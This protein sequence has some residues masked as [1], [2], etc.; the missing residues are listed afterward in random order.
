MQYS[1]GLLNLLEDTLGP[2]GLGEQPQQQQ[3]QTQQ[4]Q[5][6]GGV[7]GKAEQQQPGPLQAQ[8]QV[9]QQ[10]QPLHTAVSPFGGVLPQQLLQQQ[11]QQLGGS[12]INLV[13]PQAVAAPAALAGTQQQQQQAGLMPPPLPV[14]QQG[15]QQ[16]AA[17]LLLQ[18][19]QQQPLAFQPV[20]S[21]LLLQP[22]QLHLLRTAN[23]P[24]AV[25]QLGQQLSPPVMQLPGLQQQQQQ[26]V[27]QQQ[28]QQ[29]QQMEF[30]FGHSDGEDDVDDNKHQGQP[31]RRG[32]PPKVPGQYSKGYEAI[33]RYREKKKGMVRGTRLF[34]GLGGALRG[35]VGFQH[36]P[37]D[38]LS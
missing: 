13:M 16:L 36:L 18:E 2:L 17:G 10:P 21:P 25:P 4:Q 31:K 37:G 20:L 33:K 29:Q 22:Q 24:L 8:P 5:Q 12:S 32:R 19:Q 11:Q 34:D 15:Q 14:Q 38:G 9:T 6:Q 26:Q 30:Q 27:P 35:P 1:Q 23:A 28:Q 3:Q 7:E